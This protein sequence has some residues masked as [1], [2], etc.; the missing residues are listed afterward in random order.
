MLRSFLR[1]LQPRLCTSQVIASQQN[2]GIL[3]LSLPLQCFGQQNFMLVIVSFILMYNLQQLTF[4][5]QVIVFFY[6]VGEVD[7]LHALQ[8]LGYRLWWR[9]SN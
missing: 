8:Y 6:V 4:I 3:V 5:E 9:F 1:H 2:T 7:I